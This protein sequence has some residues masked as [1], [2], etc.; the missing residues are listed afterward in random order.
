MI[1]WML[2]LQSLSFLCSPTHWWICGLLSLIALSNTRAT[3][4]SRRTCG[5]CW[6]LTRILDKFPFEFLPHFTFKRLWKHSCYAW[7]QGWSKLGRKRPKVW[8]WPP[9]S[10]LLFFQTEPEFKSY[11]IHK[12]L[13]VNKSVGN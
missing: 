7:S 9:F 11:R 12:S 10:L 1:I 5:F 13:N 8:F 4:F 3:K 6:A 2:N